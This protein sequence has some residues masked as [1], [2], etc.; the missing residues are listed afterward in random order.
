VLVLAL[1]AAGAHTT[2]LTMLDPSTG[3]EESDQL[4]FPLFGGDARVDM[5]LERRH[6]DAADEV[7]RYLD[8]LRLPDGSVLVDVFE[9]Y[10]IVL[11]S[12]RPK[13]FVITP[14]RDFAAALADPSIF[15]VRYILAPYP[16]GYGLLSSVTRAYPD[17]YRSGAGIASLVETFDTHRPFFRWRLYAVTP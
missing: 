7:A 4:R 6:L 15:G 17:L 1:L 11:R 13:Q 3:P 9:G 2:A 8:A 16:I 10:A 5:P 14:D 12:E